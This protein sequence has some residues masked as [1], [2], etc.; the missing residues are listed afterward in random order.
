MLVRITGVQKNYAWGSGFLIQDHLGIGTLGEPLAEVWFG[1]HQGGKSIATLSGESLDKLISGKLPFLAKFLAAQSPLSIQ[2]HPNPKQAKAGFE[3]ENQAGLDP[4]DPSRNYPDD[5]EKPEVLIALTNFRALCGFRPLGEIRQILEA[6]SK[7]DNRFGELLQS[8]DLGLS[9]RELFTVLLQD[10]ALVEDVSSKGSRFKDLAAQALVVERARDLMLELVD[11]YPAD[12][13]AL[14]AL[15]LN[16]VELSPGQAIY[17]PAGNLHAYLSGLGFEVMAASNNVI[18]GGLTPKHIDQEELLA[19][20]DFTELL[21]PLVE[22]RKLATGFIEY[23]VGARAFKVYKAE[24]SSSNLLIDI[25][26]VGQ[27]VVACVAGEVA[28]SNSLEEREV[29]KKGE[30][31]FMSEAKKFSLSGSGTVFVVLG[32]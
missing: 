18:R 23:E 26:L 19:I 8:L 28:L 9:L 5:S 25:D 27:S 14:V 22:P 7:A 21:K 24:V 6:F 17:L 16:E 20:T 29:L 10:K 31:A 15:L 3:R 4:S 13:G 11:R 32:S 12:T 2:V 30:V 1:T